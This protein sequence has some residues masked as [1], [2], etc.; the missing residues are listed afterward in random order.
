M[1]CEGNV[2]GKCKGIGLLVVGLLVVLN[3]WLT[4]VDWWMLIGVLLALKG[5]MC[6]VKPNGC[7]C[8]S[9][10]MPKALPKKKK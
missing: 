6:V 8:C 7:G 2:C 4:L 5:L 10:E 1:G 3:S 9:V